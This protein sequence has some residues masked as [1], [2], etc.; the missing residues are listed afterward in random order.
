M[1]KAFRRGGRRMVAL[2]FF[3]WALCTLCAHK[4]QVNDRITNV[5]S[6]H[7]KPQLILW[8]HYFCHR[9]GLC[10]HISPLY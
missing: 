6:R 9:R 8:G 2:S 3:L 5:P 7:D 4:A 1:A 10:A